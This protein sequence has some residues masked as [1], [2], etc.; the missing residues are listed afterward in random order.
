MR[1]LLGPD[2][3]HDD[4]GD[5]DDGDDV[6]HD[7]VLRSNLPHGVARQC[8]RPARIHR[9][10]RRQ[11]LF[12]VLRSETVAATAEQFRELHCSEGAP[13]CGRQHPV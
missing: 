10:R 5:D 11:R 9:R 8:R 6:Y 7:D 2:D 12:A 3:Y 1:L 13:R 4:V